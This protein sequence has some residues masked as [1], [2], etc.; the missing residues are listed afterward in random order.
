MYFK[1][2]EIKILFWELTTHYIMKSWDEMATAVLEN[3]IK[4]SV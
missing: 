2:W 4:Y 1:W 3:K